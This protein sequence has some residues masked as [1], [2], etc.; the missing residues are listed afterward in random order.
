MVKS[1]TNSLRNQAKIFSESLTSL[2]LLLL[3]C[4]DLMSIHHSIT[5]LSLLLLSQGIS[6]ASASIYQLSA[7]MTA[8]ETEQSVASANMASSTVA[9]SK[10]QIVGIEGKPIGKAEESQDATQRGIS[11]TAQ[12]KIDFSQ[13]AL[14]AT[15]SDLD[16]ALQGQGVFFEVENA[17]G[18]KVLTRNGRFQIS[19]GNDQV[20]QDAHGDTVLGEGGPIL[21]DGTLGPVSA[22]RDGTIY[23]SGEARGKITVV[24]VEK[25]EKLLTTRG[26]FKLDEGADTSTPDPEDFSV[27]HGMYEASN[28]NTVNTMAEMMRL[29]QHYSMAASQISNISSLEQEAIGNLLSL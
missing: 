10:Q 15:G 26:G 24:K 22:A 13:G 11:P 27:H 19:P 9:G 17:D 16:F 29:Q 28:S 5:A 20:L 4:V 1:T 2:A 23:Q 25:L 18:E 6:Y 14:I 21:I 3:H 8:V 7:L 12:Q